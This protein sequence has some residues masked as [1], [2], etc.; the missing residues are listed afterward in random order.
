ME[1]NFSERQSVSSL[2][3]KVGNHI[4]PQIIRFKYLGSIVQNDGE[5]DRDVNH[6][7]Q[8]GWLKW[9]RALF[10]LCDTKVPLRLKGKFYRTSVKPMM[11]FGTECWAVKNQHE[12]KLSIVE[13]RMLRWM[14]GKTR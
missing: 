14:C 10:V 4:I 1:C 13:M 6:Q 9:R 2:E 5:I 8:A 7:I 12:N 3:V 11:L